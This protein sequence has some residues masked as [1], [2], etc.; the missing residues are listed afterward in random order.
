MKRV[1]VLAIGVLALGFAPRDGRADDS[2]ETPSSPVAHDPTCE[3]VNEEGWVAENPDGIHGVWYGFGDE[4][5]CPTPPADFCGP[6]GC[7]LSGS[8]IVDPTWAAWGCGL[9]LVLN[10]DDESGTPQGYSGDATGFRIVLQGDTGGLSP[11]IV[12]DQGPDAG[13]APYRLLPPL[14][15]RAEFTVLFSEATYPDWCE[16]DAGCA[17]SPGETPDPG[18]TQGLQLIMPGAESE[19]DFDLCIASVTPVGAECDSSSGGPGAP[20]WRPKWHSLGATCE[21]FGTLVSSSGEY[22]VNNNVWGADTAQCIEARETPAGISFVVTETEHENTGFLPASYASIVRGWHWG[23]WTLD[24]GMPVRIS[25]LTSVPTRWHMK[26]DAPGVYDVLYDI[27]IMPT[28]DP[29]ISEAPE[30]TLELGVGLLPPE[31]LDFGM[32]PLVETI[33]GLEGGDW[34]V[35]AIPMGQVFLLFLRKS[36]TEL[37]DFDLKPFI[38]EAV[39]LGYAESDWYLFNVEAGFEIWQGGEGLR[40]I[41]YSVEVNP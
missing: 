27:W 39:R 24:S 15:G 14:S 21:Q 17:G 13:F 35:Y 31:H 6:R 38:D 11:R 40:T 20:E 37:V 26:T 2:P 36:P 5:A 29:T 30:G 41:S 25:D 1:P 7:C 33:E 19:A 34:D 23:S 32:F 22:T 3:L 12:F 8:T 10:L 16:G 28:G 18:S 9:G 4:I